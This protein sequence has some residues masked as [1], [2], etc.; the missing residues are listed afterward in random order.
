M[1]KGFQGVAAFSRDK[2]TRREAPTSLP[3]AVAQASPQ[4]LV[5]RSVLLNSTSTTLDEIDAQES[6]SAHCSVP[7]SKMIP[8]ARPCQNRREN[9][10]C[11]GVWVA[12]PREQ[13]QCH[14]AMIGSP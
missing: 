10:S 7:L 11:S 12:R 14:A 3:Q 5:F 2:K 1:R 13:H 6:T 8:L 9:N 4:Q